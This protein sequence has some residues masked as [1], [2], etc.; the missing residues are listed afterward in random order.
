M[1]VVSVLVGPQGRRNI[2]QRLKKL[3]RAQTPADS[4]AVH[5]A[6]QCCDVSDTVNR[7]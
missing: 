6:R 4:R 1:H 7:G 5:P 2:R 3:S